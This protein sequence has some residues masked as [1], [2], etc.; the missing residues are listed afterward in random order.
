MKTYFKLALLSWLTIGLLAACGEQDKDKETLFVPLEPEL[1]EDFTETALGLNLEMVYVKGG[2]F[3][4]G[5]TEDQGL[6]HLPDST[7]Q[8]YTRKTKLDS[9]HI[10][11]YEVTQAQWEA[12]MG[13]TFED[14]MA[15]NVEGRPVSPFHFGKGDNYP[16]YFVNQK[17]AQAFCQ[18]LSEKTGKKY[19]LPTSAQWEYA[20]R[21]GVHKT[22]TRYAGS[23]NIEEVAWYK[24][25]SHNIG[26]EHP[27]YGVHPVGTKKANALGIYDM[28]GNAWEWCSDAS[29]DNE[30]YDQTDDYNPQGPNKGEN[31]GSRVNR[32][33]DWQGHG[34]C[35]VGF[36]C[37]A[38]RAARTAAYGVSFGFRVV[39][40]P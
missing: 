32:G 6:D 5:Y 11:K 12:V 18:K 34:Y 8:K 9:Y 2:E 14:Q 16:I 3:M 15:K 7:I 37:N 36:F 13:T 1:Q 21:G 31:W 39:L 19:V 28:S 25:N 4:M 23:N 22:K 30:G 10:G 27:D 17:E 29:Y 33:G 38:Y 20:A 40:L 26:E 35:R 24:D